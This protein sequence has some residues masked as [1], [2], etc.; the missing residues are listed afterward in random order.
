[1]DVCQLL[2]SEYSVSS[3]NKTNSHSKNEILLKVALSTINQP[4]QLWLCETNTS[5]VDVLSCY[6]TE[7]PACRRDA[8][9]GHIVLTSSQL[10]FDITPSCCEEW[11]IQ[12]QIQHLA[13]DTVQRQT[14]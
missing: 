5:G 10:G 3:T 6:P 4:N 14:K 1:M 12:R 9:L 11:T 2:F 7:Q 8:R 13:H